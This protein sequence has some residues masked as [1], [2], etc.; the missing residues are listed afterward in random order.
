MKK[1]LKKLEIY[2][3]KEYVIVNNGIAKRLKTNEIIFNTD[4]I[5]NKI[6][7]DNIY[8]ILLSNCNN[9]KCS[10]NSPPHYA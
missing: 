2:T 5:Y 10:L 6:P 9:K 1:L 3:K 4:L 8:T 7:Q